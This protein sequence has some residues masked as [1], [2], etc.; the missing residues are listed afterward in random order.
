M[1]TSRNTWE[2]RVPTTPNT[3][4]RIHDR[5]SAQRRRPARAA[6]TGGAQLCPRA[7]SAG[8]AA[9]SQSHSRSAIAHFACHGTTDPAD[10]ADPSRSGLL[11]G[12]DHRTGPL[13]VAALAPVRLDAAELAYLSACSTALNEAAALAD[14]SILVASAFQLAGFPHV[15][16]TL[17]E[18]DDDA[19]IAIAEKFYSRLRTET[20][21]LDPSQDAAALHWMARQLR[22][23]E[24]LAPFLWA[25][26]LHAGA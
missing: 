11:L 7:F 1:I 25:A 2:R 12:D 26:H 14:E 3:P 13:T 4:G 9:T 17:W 10:P 22:D 24:P 19:A 20:G 6:G 16:G 15:V 21:A 8:S 18:I 23:D 5:T